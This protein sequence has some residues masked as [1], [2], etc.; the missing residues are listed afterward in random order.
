MDQYQI[1]QQTVL[2]KNKSNKCDKCDLKVNGLFNFVQMG[3]DRPLIK[4]F[5]PYFRLEA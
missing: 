5:Q 3:S 4:T 2:K 1:S